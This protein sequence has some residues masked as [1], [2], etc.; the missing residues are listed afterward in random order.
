M[1]KSRDDISE[2]LK[3]LTGDWTEDENEDDVDDKP[4][5]AELASELATKE[6]EPTE[7]HQTADEEEDD[8]DLALQSMHKSSEQQ[9]TT[10]KAGNEPAEEEIEATTTVNSQSDKMEVDAEAEAEAKSSAVTDVQIKTEDGLETEQEEFI[11]EEVPTSDPTH[12]EVESEAPAASAAPEG[13]DDVHLEAENIRKELLDELIAGAEKP[14]DEP[15]STPGV[16]TTSADVS[17]DAAEEEEFVPPT[18][19]PVEQSIAMDVD[20]SEAE[21]PSE[22]K[23]ESKAEEDTQIPLESETEI[24]D[25]TKP[26]ATTTAKKVDA[27]EAPAADKV[28][29]L[30]SEWVDDE[31]DE[32]ENGVSAAAKAEL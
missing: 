23:D 22:S 2:K 25:K 7:S 12:P 28:K 1:E 3:E 8:I 5:T 15:E 29:S 18:Q 20:D 11:K 21:K 16:E 24:A 14:E 17:T 19:M 9:G 27:E 6:A 31:E 30:I 13:E 4:A 10:T 32:D 26:E